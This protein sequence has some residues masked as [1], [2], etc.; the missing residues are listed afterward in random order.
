[1]QTDQWLLWKHKM[2]EKAKYLIGKP[3]M[4]KLAQNAGYSEVD[5]L[6]AQMAAID[7]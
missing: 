1:M 6:K 5:H 2:P 4:N 7:G 3:K